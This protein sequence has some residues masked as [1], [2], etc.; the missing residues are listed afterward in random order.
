MSELLVFRFNTS[1]DSQIY[2]LNEIGLAFRNFVV[3]L[4]YIIAIAHTL[5]IRISYNCF[6]PSFEMALENEI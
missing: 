4:P 3:F 2:C 1:I 6:V 5:K